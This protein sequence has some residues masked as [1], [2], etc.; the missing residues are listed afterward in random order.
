MIKSPI[1]FFV[2]FKSTP[3][4]LLEQ[5]IVSIEGSMEGFKKGSIETK[6]PNLVKLTRDENTLFSILGNSS[7]GF[8]KRLLAKFILP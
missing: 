3:D 2:E 4:L 1:Y 7:L 8:R 5:N 6:G